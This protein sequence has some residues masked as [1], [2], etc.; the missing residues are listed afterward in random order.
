M[1]FGKILG[2]FL[3]ILAIG[4]FLLI[5]S[6]GYEGFIDFI[7]NY[8]GYTDKTGIKNFF[9]PAKF[10][11][12][13]IALGVI[14]ATGIFTFLFSN[15]ITR[16]TKKILTTFQTISRDV[17]STYSTM[18]TFTKSVFWGIMLLNM[19]VKIYYAATI[20]VNHDEAMGYGLFASRG[21]L[22]SMSYYYTNN[23]ILHHI[24]VNLCAWLPLDMLVKIR[25]PTLIAN[26]LSVAAFFLIFKKYFNAKITAVLTVI[27]SFIFPILYY[28]YLSRGYSL[29]FISFMLMF[30][31]ALG[32]ID[33][34]PQFKHFLLL[35]LGGVIGLYAH[36]TFVYPAFGINCLLFFALVF[37]KNWQLLKQLIT[38]GIV[39]GICIILLYSPI[40]IFSGPDKLFGNAWTTQ[41]I[42]RFDVLKGLYPQFA[43]AFKL[44]FYSKYAILVAL[45]ITVLGLYIAKFSKVALYAF[46]L[47]LINPFILLLQSMLVFDRYWIF[48]V[49]PTLFLFGYVL[50]AIKPFHQKLSNSA[51]MVLCIGL[52]SALLWKF[53]KRV[54]YEELFSV[55][56]KT[57]S[58]YLV[59][60]NCD[61]LFVTHLHGVA[62]PRYYFVINNREVALNHVPTDEDIN[63]EA[64]KDYDFVLAKYELKSLEGTY[65][66]VFD[67]STDH[68]TWENAILYQK[69]S[70]LNKAHSSIK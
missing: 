34:K 24:L 51:I 64:V 66:K 20:P 35:T 69:I 4:T 61:K 26:F 8:S 19:V 12:F 38:S 27:F 15:T 55:Y 14:L 31:A 43:S 37:Q 22:V 49:V 33:N 65:K 17:S 5:N 21:L 6:L 62:I 54:Q 70:S 13:K 32:I 50:R 25:I 18:D 41:P 60:N 9:G 39:V 7:S 56:S 63:P 48:I 30:Y 59:E 40:L 47:I 42:T 58:E 36:P 1:N 67:Y 28:G 23:H 57:I 45:P 16:A 53:D 3:S 68:R 11:L 10:K 52:S 44:L 2:G 29:V 46:L